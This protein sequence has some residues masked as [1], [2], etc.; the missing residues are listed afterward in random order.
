MLNKLLKLGKKSNGYYLELDESKESTNGKVAEV[1]QAVV[2]KTTKVKEVAAE[3]TAK[4]K[5][6]A[7]E[8]TK[9][10]EEA[11]AEKTAPVKEAVAE[12]VT[13]AQTAVAEKTA[14]VKAPAQTKSKKAKKSKAAKNTTEPTQVTPVATKA[15]SAGASTYEQPFWVKVMY[16]K[17]SSNGNGKAGSSEQTFATDYLITTTNGYR[18]RPGPSLNKFKA[19]ASKTKNI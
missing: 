14:P 10:V 17:S 12:T 2:E 19:M 3:K 15:P 16:E 1:A 5:K 9:K 8:K 7:V 13:A 18:R 11:V 4:V 6:A